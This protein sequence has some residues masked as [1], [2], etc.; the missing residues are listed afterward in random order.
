MG[1]SISKNVSSKYSQKLF[2]H[3][4]QSCKNALKTPSKRENSK[5]SRSN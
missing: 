2:A 4:K 1:K 3:A 5:N